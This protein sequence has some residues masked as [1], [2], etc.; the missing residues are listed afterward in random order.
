MG[1]TSIFMMEQNKLLNRQGLLMILYQMLST[2]SFYRQQDIIGGVQGCLARWELRDF[3]GNNPSQLV[4]LINTAGHL[5]LMPITYI[6]CLAY[7]WISGMD[8]VHSHLNR[9]ESKIVRKILKIKY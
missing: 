1:I 3:I 5:V 6:S 8:C 2:I 4:F 7:L 9:V